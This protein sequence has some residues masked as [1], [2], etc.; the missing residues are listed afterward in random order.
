MAYPEPA[1]L[2]MQ[3]EQPNIRTVRAGSGRQ[4]IVTWKGSAESPVDVLP[5]L[6]RYAVF[7]PLLNGDLLFHRAHVGD[8]GWSVQWTEALEISADTLWRLTLEQG[9]AWLHEWR[10]TR[11]M[12]QQQAAQALGVSPRMWR[13]YEAGT[14]LLPKTVRLAAIGLDVQARAA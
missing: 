12:T 10:T 2:T 8:W 4:L 1:R 13:Y 3:A 11:G 14:H 9:A 7:A 6:A 5:H